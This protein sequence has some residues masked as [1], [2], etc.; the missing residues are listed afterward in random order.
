MKSTPLNLVGRN[1]GQV[2]GDKGPK[3]EWHYD[4]VRL[5]AY[6]SHPPVYDQKFGPDLHWLIAAGFEVEKYADIYTSRVLGTKSPLALVHL[7]GNDTRDFAFT[8]QEASK[9]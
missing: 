4:Q 3:D 9:L 8:E 1:R 6:I 2:A 5:A 7:Q